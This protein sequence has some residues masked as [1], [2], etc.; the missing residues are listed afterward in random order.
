[1]C[2]LSPRF[3]ANIELGDALF[4]IDTLA[5]ISRNLLCTTDYIMFGGKY[6]NDGT[7][8]DA[9]KQIQLLDPVFMPVVKLFIQVIT[10]TENIIRRK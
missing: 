10:E 2:N 3:I 8:Q 7:W 9:I 4:S 5:R 1:M 6:E